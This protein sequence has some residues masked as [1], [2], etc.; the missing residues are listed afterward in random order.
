MAIIAADRVAV[1]RETLSD[2]RRRN[3]YSIDLTRLGQRPEDKAKRLFISE[4][5]S[6]PRGTA[7][8]ETIAK[9]KQAQEAAAAV[10]TTDAEV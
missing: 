7:V 1:G 8:F 10:E 6:R 5:G 9:L 3:T 2:I 4:P